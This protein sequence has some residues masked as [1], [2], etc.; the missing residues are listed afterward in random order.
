[1]E[2]PEATTSRTRIAAA[3]LLLGV[4]LLFGCGEGG[5][6]SSGDAPDPRPP[7]EADPSPLPDAGPCSVEAVERRPL[8][9][10]DGLH[11]YV[12]PTNFMRVGDDFVVVGS[13]TYTWEVGGT[14]AGMASDRAH[15]AAYLVEEAPRLVEKPIAGTVGFTR[16]VVLGDRRWGVL[17]EEEGP[18]GDS[19]DLV[20]VRYAEYDGVGWSEVERL[21]LPPEGQ[22]IVGSS[23]AL[24]THEGVRRW[25]VVHNPGGA[26]LQYERRDGSW[27]YR[28]IAD[29]GVEA[30][31]MAVGQS[32]TWLALSGLDPGISAPVKSVRLF[33]LDDGWELVSRNPTVEPYTEIPSI[34]VLALPGGAALTWIESR[35]SS[36]VMARVGVRAGRPGQLLLVDESAAV[37]RPFATRDGE[38]AWLVQHVNEIAGSS[39]LRLRR[40]DGRGVTTTLSIPYPYTGFFAPIA[41]S[42][43]EEVLVTGSEFSPD[44]ARPTVRS[45]TLRLYPSCR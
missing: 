27:S 18:S 35:G 25:T 10:P 41:T 38:P 22:V 4:A 8:V 24:V 7:T 5:A 15:I 6:G 34:S 12:E 14:R 26:A 3:G 9:L 30:A 16:S 1:M 33:R 28:S 13:P 21:P 17:F 29:S 11:A 2:H 31:A 40:P 37:V 43:P 20:G 45:L 23:S 42:E 32:D 44:P 36:I 19:G 39:E